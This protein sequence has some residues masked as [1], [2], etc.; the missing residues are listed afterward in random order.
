MSKL[1]GVAAVLKFINGH[2][3]GPDSLRAICNYTKDKDKTKDGTL[4]ATHGCSREHP[5]EDMLCNKRLHNKTHGKQYEHFVLAPYP[6]GS[7]NSPEKVLKAAKEI[8]ATVFPEHMAVITVH[9]DTKVVHAHTVL[10]AVNAVTGRKFSQSPSDLN[11]VKQK[12]NNILVK[13]GFE[14]ITASANDFVDHTDYS[15][16]EGFDFLELDEFEMITESD[17]E[18]ISEDTDSIRSNNTPNLSWNWDF[19]R[20]NNN[21]YGGYNMNN[22]NYPRYMSQAQTTPASVPATTTPASVGGTETGKMMMKLNPNYESDPSEPPVIIYTET[23]QT[24]ETK[25]EI[26]STNYGVQTIQESPVSSPTV[27]VVNSELPAAQSTQNMTVSSTSFDTV[28]ATAVNSYPNTSVVTSPIFRIKGN[29]DA[30]LAGFNELVE[31]TMADAQKRQRDVA[32]L[33]LAMQKYGQQTGYPSNVSIYA[34]P[35]FDIDMTGGMYQPL[36]AY[37]TNQSLPGYDTNPCLPGYNKNKF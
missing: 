36:P 22:V 25:P 35:I 4:I 32:N 29:P 16:E 33:A 9:T 3:A 12:V 11:R 8:V 14:I 5:V 23:A 24:T 34:G 19:P 37:D 6:N 27:E 13:H 1:K 20:Y 10:D 18:E 31:Y 15:K 7:D 2:N 30:N 17:I 21:I 26:E 28:P